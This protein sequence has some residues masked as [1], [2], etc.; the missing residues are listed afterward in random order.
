M[1]VSARRLLDLPSG[2]DFAKAR[3]ARKAVQTMQFAHT[4]V[5]GIRNTNRMI[6]NHIPVN[7]VGH[8]RY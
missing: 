6:A 1:S 5:G 7:A 3:T 8:E 4:S 2:M